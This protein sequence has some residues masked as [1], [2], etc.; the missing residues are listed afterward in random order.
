MTSITPAPHSRFILDFETTGL[1]PATDQV[2]EVGLRGP[3]TLDALVSNAR[4]ASSEA[5]AVHGL[6]PDLCRCL[7]RPSADVLDDLLGQLGPGPVEVVA[8]NASFERRFLE[9]WVAREGRVLPEI[10][11]QCTLE[12]AWALTPK[13]P[14]S[15]RLGA[16]AELFGWPTEGLHGAGIDATLAERLVAVLDAWTAVRDRLGPDPGLVYLAGPF[17]GDGTAEAMAHNR[18]RMAGLARWAQAVL[19]DATLVVPHLNFAYAD[20]AGKHGDR[21]RAQVLHSCEA[22]VARC[23]AL[24]QCG[25][26]RTE[27]M[28]REIA[29]AEAMGLPVL[30]VPGW[31]GLRREPGLEVRGVA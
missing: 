31:P 18:V 13:A 7:G 29:V 1:D 2:L 26:H 10:R 5:E 3:A 14:F 20:E 11:W 21:I 17:R 12:R 22:L 6:D 25:S 19:P 15:C 9:A 23:Q 24:I 27:G 30:Q 8:H 28:A 16:L 4:P